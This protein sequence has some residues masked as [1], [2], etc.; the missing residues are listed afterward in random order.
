[1]NYSYELIRLDELES[2]ISTKI[3]HV[4]ILKKLFILAQLN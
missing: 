1:V 3:N 2:I 4:F